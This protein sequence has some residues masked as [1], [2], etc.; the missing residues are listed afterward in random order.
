MKPDASINEGAQEACDDFDVD[1]DCDG[2]SDDLDN[3]GTVSGALTFFVDND[4]D[5]S[6][7]NV[8][9]VFSCDGNSSSGASSLVYYYTLDSTN[10]SFLDSTASGQCICPTDQCNEACRLVSDSTKSCYPTSETAYTNGTS[11]C[12]GITSG[13]NFNVTATPFDFTASS[14]ADFSIYVQDCDDSVGGADVYPRAPESCDGVLNDCVNSAGGVPTDEVDFDNDGYVECE[15]DGSTWNGSNTPLVGADCSPRD[16]NVFPNAPS[17]CDGQ[18]NNC[19][20][21]RPTYVDSTRECFCYDV[22]SSDPSLCD[23]TSCVD[24]SGSHVYT[25]TGYSGCSDMYA[26]V[27]CNRKIQ[28]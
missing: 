3:N 25:S 7:T 21:W 24:S 1:E 23:T 22:D 15:F 28:R 16:T 8:G 26:V 20:S 4:G 13:S 5:G 18:Y 10:T 14:F 27:R 19:D 9:K 17:I 11:Y 6:P 2:L 12:A